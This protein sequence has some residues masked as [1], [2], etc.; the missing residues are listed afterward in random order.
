MSEQIVQQEVKSYFLKKHF[1]NFKVVKALKDCNNIE[2]YLH[3]KDYLNKFDYN[4]NLI[5]SDGFSNEVE[6]SYFIYKGYTPN[7]SLGLLKKYTIL[8]GEVKKVIGVIESDIIIIDLYE[9][10]IYLHSF[11]KDNLYITGYLIKAETKSELNKNLIFSNEKV[12][13]NIKNI[14]KFDI[15]DVVDDFINKFIM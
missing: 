5:I 1:F 3:S 4:L 13:I 10:S 9:K 8:N 2:A 15:T 14:N 6:N 12:K 7:G 11:T